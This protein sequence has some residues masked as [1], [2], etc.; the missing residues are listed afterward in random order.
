M[1]FYY[2]YNFSQ[3]STY[4]LG[5]DVVTL[6]VYIYTAVGAYEDKSV[7]QNDTTLESII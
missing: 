3:S 2:Q 1:Q 6:A 7:V 5:I 4:A